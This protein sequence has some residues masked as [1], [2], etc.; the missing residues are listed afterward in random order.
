MKIKRLYEQEETYLCSVE[1]ECE[2]FELEFEAML[3]HF[4]NGFNLANAELLEFIVGEKE[5]GVSLTV[6]FFLMDFNSKYLLQI[7][8]FVKF[9]EKYGKYIFIPSEPETGND[10]RMG[11]QIDFLFK[12]L[13][14]MLPKLKIMADT[15]KYNL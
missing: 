12:D 2:K 13:K 6:D 15:R 1:A 7:T 3:D 5:M 11:I 8:N 14:R 4:F 9:I 10:G